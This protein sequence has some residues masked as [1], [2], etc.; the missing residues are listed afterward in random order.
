MLLSKG[1]RSFQLDFVSN[2]S[3]AVYQA[4]C[5]SK[6]YLKTTDCGS[7]CLALEYVYGMVSDFFKWLSTLLFYFCFTL[8]LWQ[9]WFAPVV[10]LRHINPPWK[11]RRMLYRIEFASFI[12]FLNFESKCCGSYL[13]CVS[14]YVYTLRI[15]RTSSY[16]SHFRVRSLAVR[17]TKSC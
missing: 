6:Y 2:F 16:P 17:T 1:S 12:V 15:Y 5:I 8:S 9:L 11:Q 4:V 14:V 10:I 13:P 7:S 3:V